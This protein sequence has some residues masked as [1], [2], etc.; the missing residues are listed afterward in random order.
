MHVVAQIG[1]ALS[2]FGLHRAA[3]EEG[4][5]DSPADS[6]TAAEGFTENIK[7]IVEPAAPESSALGEGSMAEPI[8]GGAF[9]AVHQDVVS[10]TELLKFFFG[11]RIVRIFVGMKFDGEFAV[12]ALDLVARDSSLDLEDFVIIAFRRRHFEK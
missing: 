4:L 9:V 11:V 12:G 8:V 3:A 7:R 6:A 2:I 5:E 10:F 1:T